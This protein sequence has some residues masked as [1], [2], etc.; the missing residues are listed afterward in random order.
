V[1]DDFIDALWYA[2]FREQMRSGRAA[3]DEEYVEFKIHNPIQ[4]KPGMIEMVQG[5]DGVWRESESEEA[6]TARLRTYYEMGMLV[7]PRPTLA[8]IITGI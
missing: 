7:H 2:A 4:E 3:V 8:N 5:A 6:R 1:N